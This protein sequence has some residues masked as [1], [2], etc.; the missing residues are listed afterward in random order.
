M[1]RNRKPLDPRWVLNSGAG[2]FPACFNGYQQ[3]QDWRYYMRVSLEGMRVGVCHDCTPEY[4]MEMMCQGRC[5]HPETV[6]VT[7]TLRSGDSEVIGVAEGTPYWEQVQE[8]KLVLVEQ[9][10]GED[11]Q[12]SEGQNG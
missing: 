2:R 9:D 11:Q 7:R 10:N 4:K 5:E 3:Y 6:F 8:G 12:P 1:G